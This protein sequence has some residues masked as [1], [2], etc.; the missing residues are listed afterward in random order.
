MKEYLREYPQFALCGLNCGLCPRHHT[1]GK[2]KC[3]GCGGED[4]HLQH[5]SCAVI[6]CSRKHGDVEFC[7]QCS[8][9]PCE[10]YKCTSSSDSF[11]SYQNVLSD[12][13]KARLNGIESYIEELDE[14]V[15]ILEF[16]IE[17]YNDGRSK[18]FYCIAVNLLELGELRKIMKEIKDSVSKQD[19][20]QESK[21]RL[22]RSLIE[23]QAD[24]SKIELNLRK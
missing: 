2:S 17:N 23:E 18:N 7:F 16:L 21:I 8:D 10:K 6:T 15:K 4:F 14:K 24:H 9:F 22:V 1:D 19:I 13:E 3:P 5:P 12:F 11:I 20:P